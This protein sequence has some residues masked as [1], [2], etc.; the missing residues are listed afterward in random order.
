MIGGRR[1]TEWSDL[2]ENQ[3][4]AICYS[5]GPLLIIAGP[6]SGK[7]EVLAWRVAYLISAGIAK[8][9]KVLVATFADKAATELKDRIQEKIPHINVEM[10]QV[11]TIH[12]FCLKLLYKYD[13]YVRMP[14]DFRVLGDLEQLLFIYSHHEELGFDFR[15]DEDPY[16]LLSEAQHIFNLATE[17][18][19]DPSDL[20]DWCH[21][22]L[23]N[24]AT[25]ES[26]AWTKWTQIA[27]AYNRYLKLLHSEGVLDS[28]RY[29]VAP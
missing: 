23:E 11:S 19:V 3:K 24:C 15:A 4:E 29:R 17:E 28:L 22:N 2:T 1:L 10:M 7:T 16:S 25:A 27:S 8:S 14:V 20:A 26:E 13:R 6:G 21:L 18:L 9:D 5:G 12:S